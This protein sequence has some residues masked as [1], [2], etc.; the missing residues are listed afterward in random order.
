MGFFNRRP[1]ALTD[2]ELRDTLFDAVA[3][4]NAFGLNE[5][6]TKHGQR[7]TALFPAWTKLPPSVRSDPARTNW[8]AAGMIGIASTAA[9]L[10]DR[11]LMAC[12]IGPPGENQIIVWGEAF[13]AAEADAANGLLSSAIQR[14]EELLA[15]IASAS[16]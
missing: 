14:L 8:W 9:R 3:E 16:L 15:K 6:L 12:L 10:G 11:S 5:L 4:S 13:H 7:V 2:D 1:K